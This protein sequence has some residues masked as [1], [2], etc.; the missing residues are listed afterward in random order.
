MGLPETDSHLQ[1][2]IERRLRSIVQIGN[3]K[4]QC[5]RFWEMVE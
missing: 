2:L 5:G 3:E 1:V 4:E